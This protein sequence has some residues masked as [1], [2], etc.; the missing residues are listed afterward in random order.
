[1]WLI[2]T[3]CR[4]VVLPQYFF[5]DSQVIYLGVVCS[6]MTDY[7]LVSWNFYWI[8]VFLLIDN[9]THFDSIFQFFDFQVPY[10]KPQMAVSENVCCYNSFFCSENIGG[11]FVTHPV[12]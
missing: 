9:V 12:L 2:L 4:T 1:M 10:F 7:V 5:L 8:K 11:L 6:E 3:I